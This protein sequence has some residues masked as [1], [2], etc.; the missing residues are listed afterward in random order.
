MWTT[1]FAKCL[2]TSLFAGSS[3]SNL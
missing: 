3:L 2:I 1:E